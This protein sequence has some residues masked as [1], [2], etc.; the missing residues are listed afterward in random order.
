MLLLGGTEWKS[1]EKEVDVTVD[2]LIAFVNYLPR[3]NLRKLAD[4]GATKPSAFH[5]H[6]HVG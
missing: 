4:A 1:G 2:N 3:G 6:I 5:V